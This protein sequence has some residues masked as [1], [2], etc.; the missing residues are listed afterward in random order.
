M[1]EAKESPVQQRIHIC[2][3]GTSTSS[4]RLAQAKKARFS[5]SRLSSPGFSEGED[6]LEAFH[7]PF[8]H[9]GMARDG[10]SSSEPS[11]QATNPGLFHRRRKEGTLMVVHIAIMALATCSNA[12]STDCG[13]LAS[14]PPRGIPFALTRNLFGSIPTHHVLAAIA[15]SSMQKKEH[16]VR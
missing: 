4:V 16:I 11:P 6:H 5:S 9:A 2:T 3:T 7:W 15:E 1:D 8:P 10:R 14:S 12:L 13:T